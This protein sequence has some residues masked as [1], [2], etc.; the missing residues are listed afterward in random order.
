MSRP[1][2]FLCGIGGYAAFYV[3]ALL[4]PSAEALPF[5]FVGAADPFAE[6]CARYPELKAAGVPVYHD[7]DEFFAHDSCELCIV[8]SPIQFH[9][10][11]TRTAMEHGAMVL[12][13]KPIGATLSQARAMRALELQY[14]RPIMIGFQW[15]YAPGVLALK[16]DIMAG[17]YGRALE[18]RTM[19]NWPR[20]AQYYARPW[21]GRIR[22]ESGRDV[23]DSIANNA[24]AHYIHNLL[25]M[26]GE[27]MDISAVPESVEAQLY[28]ANAIENFDTAFIKLRA[29]GADLLFAAS[30]AGSRNGAPRLDYRFEK[31]RI[32][33]LGGGDA[34]FTLC[35]HTDAGDVLYPMQPSNDGKFYAALRALQGEKQPCTTL[36]A[37]PHM[38]CIDALTRM[39]INTV[40]SAM[41]KR[42][43]LTP[44]DPYNVVDGMDET[45]ER[46]FA[47][48]RLPAPGDAPFVCQTTSADIAAM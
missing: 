23:Y 38:L 45:L 47:S 18:L 9:L 34:D 13:E 28:R 26:L 3:D 41:I 6:R 20:G 11:Q 39:P 21:A 30:H 4:H 7:C 33:L 14:G 2:V 42:I 15:S 40:P 27:E 25:F 10:E 35:A 43:E 44:G 16:R 48:G 22:D 12:S 36:T 5:E 31:A 24:C 32:T 46:V 17:R 8:S 37:T 29:A 19:L 1:R